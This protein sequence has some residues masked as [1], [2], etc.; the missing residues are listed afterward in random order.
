VGDIYL[1]GQY[2]CYERSNPFSLKIQEIF[3]NSDVVIG[4]LE[5]PIMNRELITKDLS[6]FPTKLLQV[7]LPESL[8]TFKRYFDVFSLA[9]NHIFDYGEVGLKQTLNTLKK[10]G[11]KFTGAGLDLKSAR[12]PVI[13]NIGDVDLSIHAYCEHKTNDMKKII[14]ATD[15]SYGVSPLDLKNVKVD[16]KKSSCKYKIVLLHWGK[17]YFQYPD[18]R[19][20]AQSKKIIDFGGDVIIGTHPHVI[21]PHMNYK[22]KKVF[23]SVQFVS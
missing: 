4:N 20:I 9:N 13:I 16:L 5:S 3:D 12:K 1:G 19:R 21:I 11:I 10:N 7:A 15:D 22:G 17:E 6:P 2:M 23:F 18:P 8:E 14:A